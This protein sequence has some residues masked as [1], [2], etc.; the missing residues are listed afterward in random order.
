MGKKEPVIKTK[1]L[2]IQPMTNEEI[3][4]AIK[5]ESKEEIKAAYEEMLQGCKEN[6]ENRIWYAPWKMTLKKEGISLG[7]L[8]FKGSTKEHSVEIGYGIREEY[9]GNG[10]TTEAVGALMDWAF[11]QKDVVFIEAETEPENKASQRVLEKLGFVFDREGKEGPRFVAEQPLTNWMSI[12]M[13]FGL[14]IGMSL[15]SAAD[16]IGVGMSLGMCIGMC[17]GIALDSYLKKDREK[18]KEERKTKPEENE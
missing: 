12:Y 13:L 15:G 1:R 2:I 10:Y 6:E 17:I 8:G 9:E 11:R 3:Q 14:S 5:V 4:H 16:K 18:L 7:E